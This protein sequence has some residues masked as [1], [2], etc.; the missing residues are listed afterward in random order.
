M[1][2][3]T[4]G[5][6]PEKKITGW[7]YMELALTAFAG[8]GIELLYAFW[9]EPLVY[10]V[11][12]RDWA[13]WQEILHW[14]ITCIT[15]GLMAWYV[16]GCAKKQY[17][18]DLF[19]KG[20]KMKPW[21]WG[22]LLVDIA[23]CIAMNYR[24]WG[25]FKIAMEFRKKGPIL[26]SFQYVYYMFETV[27]VLLIVVL[28]QKSVEMWFGHKNIPWGGIVCGLTW[29]LAHALSKGSLEMGLMGLLWGV[30]FGSAYLLTNRDCKKAYVV[31][32]V[33]FVF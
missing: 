14:I 23:V 28:G 9:L 33:M 31:L 20:K 4:A 19:E 22:L 24:D 8:L 1:K 30:L 21:Q 25:G 17:G 5:I 26:F 2:E 3:K 15:W 11:S 13:D 10:G 12:M 16:A 6:K 18:F 27:L 32:L 7:S 29:G